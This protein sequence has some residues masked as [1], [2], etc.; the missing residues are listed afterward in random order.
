[1]KQ[2][3]DQLAIGWRSIL[4]EKE[5]SYCRPPSFNPPFLNHKKW[6]SYFYWMKIHWSCLITHWSC[7][8]GINSEKAHWDDA[9]LRL[10]LSEALLRKPYW[11]ASCLETP[12]GLTNLIRLGWGSLDLPE[13]QPQILSRWGDILDGVVEALE[14]LRL[15]LAIWSP[16]N[17][18]D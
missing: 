2:A 3:I 18:G 15:L 16:I 10:L 6:F 14:L 7:L 5:N 11:D 9:C 13:S 17:V 8:N 1:M 12:L 4:I